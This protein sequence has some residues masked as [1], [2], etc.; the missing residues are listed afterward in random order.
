MRNKSSCCLESSFPQKSGNLSKSFTESIFRKQPKDEEKEVEAMSM[1]C[2]RIGVH[3]WNGQ[4]RPTGRNYEE[5][6]TNQNEEYDKINLL[7]DDHN[8]FALH[9]ESTLSN[10]NEEDDENRNNMS[11]LKTLGDESTLRDCSLDDDYERRRKKRTKGIVSN[12]KSAAHSPST[13]CNKLERRDKEMQHKHPRKH[14][15]MGMRSDS[16]RTKSPTFA[17]SYTP[18]PNNIPR[19]FRNPPQIQVVKIFIILYSFRF[20]VSLKLNRK[21]RMPKIG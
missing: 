12:C 8:T 2:L 7:P 19:V 20:I 16:Q 3:K 21:T 9:C 18:A 6:S 5:F 14:R 11:T 1:T 4:N 13:S 10:K 17:K 15:Q